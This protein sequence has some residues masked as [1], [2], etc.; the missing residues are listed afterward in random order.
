MD[1]VNESPPGQT[2]K[3]EG[4]SDEA[5]WLFSQQR[6]IPGQDRAEPQRAHGAASAASSSQGRTKRSGL[7]RDQPAGA[8]ADAGGRR[9]RGT[10]PVARHYRMARRDPP[11]PAAVAKGSDA[12]RKSARVRAGHRLRYPSGAELE[13]SGPAAPTRRD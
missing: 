7:S 12:A 9:R 5:A 3:S 13:G 10:D 8:G 11:Q 6:G 2:T 1:S 4:G